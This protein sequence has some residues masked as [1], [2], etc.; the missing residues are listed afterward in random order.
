[1][2]PAL[3]EVAKWLLALLIGIG[4][5]EAI[6]TKKVKKDAKK[7][8]VEKVGP[9]LPLDVTGPTDTVSQIPNAK[10]VEKKELK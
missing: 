10:S 2:S 8:S 7:Q 6:Q 5:Y 4:S 9:V 3:L 1:M